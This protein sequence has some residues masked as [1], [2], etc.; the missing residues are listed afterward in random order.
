MKVIKVKPSLVISK[1]FHVTKENYEEI[2][3]C[4]ENNIPFVY[5]YKNKYFTTIE[6]D[7][8]DICSVC[9]FDKECQKCDLRNC[10]FSNIENKIWTIQTVG[11]EVPEYQVL[12]G[13]NNEKDI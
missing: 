1:I 3:E 4:I 8:W 12:F 6:T 11:V 9:C 7:V 10:S 2:K 5:K 13:G